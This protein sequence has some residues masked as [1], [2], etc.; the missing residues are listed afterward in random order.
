M[1]MTNN[2]KLQKLKVDDCTPKP[3][4]GTENKVYHKQSLMWSGLNCVI[5][6]LPSV[7]IPIIADHLLNDSPCCC[8][9]YNS[10]LL[11]M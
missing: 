9:T 10:C 6:D 2:T 8:Y 3:C 11:F 5:K 7:L 1:Y 4:Y